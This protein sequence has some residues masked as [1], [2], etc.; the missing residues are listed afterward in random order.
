MHDVEPRRAERD[1]RGARATVTRTVG[2]SARKA[3]GH[4]GHVDAIAYVV[5]VAEA[6]ANQPAHQLASRSAR[7]RPALIDLHRP[8]SLSDEQDVLPG[9]TT[10]DRVRA[11]DVPGVGA[12]RAGTVLALQS[13][14]VAWRVR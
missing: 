5:L 4:R 7:K 6:G 3:G 1:L 8:G 14:G 12:A 9:M 13:R 11:R 2:A 10:E